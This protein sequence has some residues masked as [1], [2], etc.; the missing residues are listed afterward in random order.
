MAKNFIE[1]GKRIV[2]TQAA[3]VSSGD[4]VIV[5]ALA[6]VALTD[7]AAGESGAAAVEGVWE[8]ANK[9]AGVTISQGDSLYWDADGDP[10]GGDA[11]TGCITNVAADTYIG[12]AWADAASTDT[13]VKAKIN[14]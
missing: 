7:V 12:M 14:V 13:T 4:L 3:A 8:L 2:V 11:G 6:T 5:G 9:A 10:Q 1:E